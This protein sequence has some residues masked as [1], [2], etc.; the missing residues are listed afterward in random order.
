MQVRCADV[1]ERYS[2]FS[3]HEKI[4]RL[5]I[6]NPGIATWLSRY[7]FHFSAIIFHVDSSESYA[8]LDQD[9]RQKSGTFPS[10]IL[11]FSTTR[12]FFC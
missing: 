2:P 10:L 1:N 3:V 6:E 5:D 11:T 9:E 4:L 8:T 7:S 12:C